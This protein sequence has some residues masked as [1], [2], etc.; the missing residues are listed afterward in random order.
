MSTRGETLARRLTARLDTP[1]VGHRPGL[2]AL[3]AA[4]PAAPIVYPRAAGLPL[5]GRLIRRLWT[6]L[7]TYRALKARV[8]RLETLLAVLAARD[9]ALATH[10]ATHA[11]PPSEAPSPSEATCAS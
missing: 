1:R 8:A 6:G 2:P 4:P 3:P 11:P 7:H 5:V 10:I 9:E